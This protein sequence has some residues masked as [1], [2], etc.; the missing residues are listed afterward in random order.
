MNSIKSIQR[1]NEQ[2]LKL[3]IS[4]NGSWHAD[5]SNSAYVHIGGLPYAINE[6]DVITVFSQC[7]EIVDCNLVRD[8]DTGESKGFAFIAYADQR[9]TILAVDNF[10]AATICGRLIKVDHVSKYRVPKEYLEED[11]KKTY[12]PTG[13]DGS[14]W[15]EFKRLNEEDV[16]K[17]GKK[18]NAEELWEMEFMK[19]LKKKQKNTGN[20]REGK[21]DRKHKTDRK[22][23]GKKKERDIKHRSG[24]GEKNKKNEEGNKTN[25]RKNE[26]IGN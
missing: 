25:R 5:Y 13:P 26:D 8:N 3:G 12:Y 2:E 1:L 18:C 9:S 20:D 7:G 17:L 4:G 15:G 23:F 22:E 6:G 24:K 16:E 21:R 19:S 14:G 11:T 10:N